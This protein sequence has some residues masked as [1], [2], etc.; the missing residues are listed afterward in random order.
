VLA[1][2]RKATGALSL[3]ANCLLLFVNGTLI[4]LIAMVQLVFQANLKD[5][6]HMSAEA[7][8]WLVTIY[9]VFT[10]AWTVNI[11]HRFKTIPKSKE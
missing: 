8:W 3:I 5:M 2:I 6:L 10:L 7:M 9:V 11:I 4:F 1:K